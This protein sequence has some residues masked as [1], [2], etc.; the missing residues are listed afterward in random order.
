M[1]SRENIEAE[2]SKEIFMKENIGEK[3]NEIK[4]KS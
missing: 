4:I 3:R 1:K 2:G